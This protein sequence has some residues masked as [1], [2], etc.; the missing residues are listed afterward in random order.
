M[1]KNPFEKDL[2]NVINNIFE[3][4]LKN[5]IYCIFLQKLNN[6]Y[7]KS[8]IIQLCDNQICFYNQLCNNQIC[9]Y[10]IINYYFEYLKIIQLSNNFYLIKIKI[11]FCIVIWKKIYFQIL[12]KLI[13][14]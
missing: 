2:K 8:C 5:Y 13:K 3:N 11:L 7:K 1:I 14:I 6:D 9:L 12:L 4:N 10:N